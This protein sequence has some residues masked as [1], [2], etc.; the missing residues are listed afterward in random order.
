MEDYGAVLEDSKRV[1]LADDH[2]IVR[3]AVK[4][5]FSRLKDIKIVAE[6]E[7]G[8]TAIAQVRIHQP[9]LLVLDAAMPMARGIEVFSETRRWSPETKVV[10]LTGFT[11]VSIL[12]DWLEAGVDG[13]LL[14]S[15]AQDEMQEAFET[16]LAGGKFVGSDVQNM[17]ENE[18][19]FVSLTHR[20]REV[21]ALI[22]NGKSNVEIGDRLSI[23]KKTVEKHRGSLMAKLGVHSVADLMVYALR[24][25][26]LDE[27]RQL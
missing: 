15:S 26:L 16:A 5:I 4:L 25:G 20:E 2:A 27:H 10:L 8:I 23:S 12:A 9:D 21:L 3:D 24:E 7:D 18:P 1:I 19:P 17:L 6:A 13:I 22:A 11:S 14:K